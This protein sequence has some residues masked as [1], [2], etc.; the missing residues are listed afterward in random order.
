M[1]EFVV[2]PGE[3]FVGQTSGELI[4]TAITRELTEVFNI[5]LGIENR[6]TEKFTAYGSFRTDRSGFGTDSEAP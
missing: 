6:F 4:D 2:V 1:D 5:A 3:P